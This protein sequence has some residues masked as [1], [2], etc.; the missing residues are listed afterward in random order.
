M[1]INISEFLQPII[2]L[3]ETASD[4][5]LKIYREARK[6]FEEIGWIE[7]SMKLINI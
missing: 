4:E 3:A 2:E 1:S 6:G 7:E 5:I